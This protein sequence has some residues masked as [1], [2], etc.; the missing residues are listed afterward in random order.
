MTEKERHL[1]TKLAEDLLKMI[2][3]VIES[4][5]E[6]KTSEMEIARMIDSILDR[7]NQLRREL[8]QH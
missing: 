4:E 5:R 8:N 2:P 1:K 7:V 3:I 6:R